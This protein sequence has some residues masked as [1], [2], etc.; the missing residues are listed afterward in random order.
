WTRAT[1]P[2]ARSPPPTSTPPPGCSSCSWAATS[3][4]ARTSSSTRRTLSTVSASTCDARSRP[5]PKVLPGRGFRHSRAP[6]RRPT[7][8]AGEGTMSATLD[9]ERDVEGEEQTELKRAIGPR[10]LLLFIVGDILGTGVYA[11]TGKV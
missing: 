4:R 3:A 7:P 6:R 1:A 5:Q 11:L 2:C 10:L 8:G 9:D